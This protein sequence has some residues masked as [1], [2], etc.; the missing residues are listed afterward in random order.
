MSGQ[1][2]K[3][4]K[5]LACNSPQLCFKSQMSWFI[6]RVKPNKITKIWIIPVHWFCRIQRVGIYLLTLQK[7]YY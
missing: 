7:N 2:A 1:S 3:N 4:D 5:K 6:N